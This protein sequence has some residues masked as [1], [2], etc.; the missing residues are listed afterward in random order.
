M[1]LLFA[2]G[3]YSIYSASKAR[4]ALDMASDSIAR[5]ID[6]REP[7]EVRED[8]LRSL[9][10]EQREALTLDS[11][12]WAQ[13][14]DDANVRARDANVRAT[15]L[16]DSIRV[17]VDSS[18][19]ELV[20]SLVVEHDK[21]V[22]ALE[23]QVEILK[24]ETVALFE[25]NASMTELMHLGDDIQASLRAEIEQQALGIS[26]LERL[27]TPPFSVRFLNSAKVGIPVLAVG[28]ALGFVLSN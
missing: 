8:S 22:S 7:M 28:V 11:I 13:E 26:E 6:A 24:R 23:S 5:L 16:V 25:A 20:D 27:L 21:E 4:E 10:E 2:H 18:T 15:T 1:V 3:I 9:V 14:L 19:L 12:R 17:R